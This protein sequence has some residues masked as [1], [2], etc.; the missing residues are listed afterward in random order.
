[1]ALKLNEKSVE[2]EHKINELTQI[3]ALIDQAL[4]GMCEYKSKLN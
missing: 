4:A 2:I 3:K 1:M